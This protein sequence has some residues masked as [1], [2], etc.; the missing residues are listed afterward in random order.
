MDILEDEA[1]PLSDVLLQT[2]IEKLSLLPAGTPHGH[3]TEYL[4]SQRLRRLL[5][6][7]RTRYADRVLIFDAPPLLLSTESRALATQVGQVVFVVAEGITP[8]ARVSE[9]MAALASCPVV[10]PVLNK[11]QTRNRATY[12][13]YG[14]YG[15]YGASGTSGA[16]GSD[17]GAAR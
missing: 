7:M 9:A 14:A 10:L 15:V 12:G 11:A 3:A 13:A 17:Q 6:D 5:D 16:P 4:S 1:M 8:V 2:T